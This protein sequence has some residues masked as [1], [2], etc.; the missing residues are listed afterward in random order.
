MA[1]TLLKFGP[2]QGTWI[3]GWNLASGEIGLPALVAP[4]GDKSVQISGVFA[5]GNVQL[6]GAIHGGAEDA[7][8]PVYTILRDLPGAAISG[9]VALY[10]ET[11]Q[12]H[13]T[14]IRPVATTVTLVSIRIICTAA[15][16]RTA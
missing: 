4:W 12:Q 7:T 1:V 2:F 9:K 11:I 10:C 16:M 8:P 3:F 5:T 6:E 14:F 15:R 13:V